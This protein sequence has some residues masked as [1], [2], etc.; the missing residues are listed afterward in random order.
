M[1]EG[2]QYQKTGITRHHVGGG[3]PQGC[4]L[5]AKGTKKWRTELP[6]VSVAVLTP[7]Q[8]DSLCRDYSWNLCLRPQAAGKFWVCSG[9]VAGTACEHR[10]SSV[11]PRAAGEA[12]GHAPCLTPEL[13]PM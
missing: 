5:L 8:T 12:G 11:L 9:D 13:F 10:E 3:L 6:S 1:W 7:E 2:Q 4:F